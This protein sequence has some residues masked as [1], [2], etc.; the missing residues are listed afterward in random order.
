MAGATAMKV[1]TGCKHELALDLFAKDRRHQGG[2][3]SR[4]KKCESARTKTFNQAKRDANPDSRQHFK[5]HVR[6]EDFVVAPLAPDAK[7]HSGKE[8]GRLRAISYGG[9]E[10]G[11]RGEW[12]CY[13]APDL[14]GC[15]NYLRVATNSLTTGN[16]RSCG[17]FQ[18]HRAS[19]E[20]AEP[21]TGHRQR[22]DYVSPVP[23]RVRAIDMIGKKVGFLTVVSRAPNYV[24]GQSTITRWNCMCDCGTPA[25]KTASMLRRSGTVSCGC[26]KHKGVP[27]RS[28]EIRARDRAYMKARREEVRFVL[29]ARMRARM[30]SALR[31]VRTRKTRRLSDILGYTYGEL[32]AHLLA[33]MP[34]GYTWQDFREG[35]LE[36][37]HIRELWR[38]NYSTEDCDEF[39]AAWALSNLQLL[40]KEA[41]AL[42]SARSE[43]ERVGTQR[44]E[45][46]P[47]KVIR[48]L[49]ATE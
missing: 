7:D 29:E 26:M 49:L 6:L 20:Q 42:K 9:R 12:N 43:K 2:Y 40:T 41:H 8:F 10:N 16:T 19:R 13:C 47:S 24:R 35:K 11:K 14:G 48:P 23:E 36:I 22:P 37:D 45:R 18:K 44:G 25:V 1:C 33:T 38:F 17:C 30:R 39:R 21:D 15:G 46:R 34:A 32:E 27:L 3:G 28:E 31:R 5:R 4:C